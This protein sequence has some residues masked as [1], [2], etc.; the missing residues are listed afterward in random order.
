MSTTIAPDAAGIRLPVSAA[1]HVARH[2]EERPRRRPVT[3]VATA[4][5]VLAVAL[6]LR[7][8]HLASSY[9]LF[10]DETTYT[11]IARDT[12]LGA[13]PLLHGMPF[14]LHPP[15]A[16]LLLAGPARLLATQDTAA[17]VDGLRPFVAVTGALIAALVYLV[18]RQSGFRRYALVG[19]AVVALDP[20]IVSFD[21][22]VMLEA[23]AQLFAVLAIAAAVRA[24]TAPPASR[25]RWSLL[26]AV[27][28]A[29]TIATKETFGIVVLVTLVLV[30][31]TATRGQRRWPLA[32]VGGTLLG[33]GLVNVAMIDWAGLGLWWHMRT[34]GL[35]RL[36]GLQQSTGFKAEG[37][38]HSFW[39]RVLPNGAELGGTYAVLV[40]GGLSALS[41]LWRVLR[42][43]E[44]VTTLPPTGRSAARIVAIWAVCACG[45]VGYAVVFG[46]LE[47]Q[48]FYIAAVPCV[49]A[50]MIRS[51]IARRSVRRIAA[52]GIALVLLA[53]AFAWFS[54]HTA[55]DDVYSQM[56]EQLP[57][58]VAPDSTIAVTEET[59]QFVL[60]GYD[61]G[62]WVTVPDLQA[63]AVDYV[64][65]SDR[66]VEYGYG[67]ADGDFAAEV[68]A[69]GTR[70]LSIQ[71]R[72]NDLQLYDVREWTGSA[73]DS[74]A[75]SGDES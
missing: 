54:V 73:V 61:L 25:G 75:P 70:V 60:N 9:D 44:T 72:E 32:A 42:R 36:L 24:V 46:S 11:A 74:T 49:A 65:L 16:L 22:R 50:L 43:H 6:F 58:V 14:V 71:G 31:L 48:M 19:A 15:L 26:T 21:S 13:G 12:T 20:L 57:R 27:A 39:E 37:V 55:R 18:L 53:Q 10:I 23:F 5:G 51:A 41:L 33:Y 38:E 56:L 52:F 40:L 64:L 66:L 29:A 35:M 8:F 17:L 7:L 59:A 47:E 63:N 1:A 28:G 45:Y 2:R 4:F 69:N 68:R 34:D 67:L 3:T 62:Q 30:A